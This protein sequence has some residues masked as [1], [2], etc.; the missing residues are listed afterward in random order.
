MGID[1]VGAG[2]LGLLFG[3]KLVLAG[4]KVRFWTRT[5]E[6]SLLLKKEGIRLIEADGK[7]QMIRGEEF[8]AVCLN[9]LTEGTLPLIEVEWLLLTLKQKDIDESLL[10]KLKKIIQA[11]TRW[12]CFQN[13]MGHMEKIR[14]V[15][16]D[17]ILLAAITTEGAKRTDGGSVTRSGHGETKIGG[18]N[19][20][21]S[22]HLAEEAAVSMLQKAGVLTVI[23][24]NISKEIYWKLL[25]NSA[26]NPLT[27]LWRISNGQLLATEERLSILRQLCREGEQ[28][29][30][31]YGINL[32]TELYEQVV[33][34]CQATSSNTSSMLGDVLEGNPT[35]IDY[36]NGRLVEMARAKGIVAPGHEMVWRL[37]RAFEDK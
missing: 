8:E 2:A 3:S 34:V 11:S 19:D 27:A 13:G 10:Y 23:A 26:I 24:E 33:A 5:K 20:A 25:I 30:A 7:Q 12:V 36:I 32:G 1:I 9:E 17:S 6:Q 35:E 15:L 16:P 31:A 37:V 21:M 14:K 18:I 28:I 4:E 29:C 22:T